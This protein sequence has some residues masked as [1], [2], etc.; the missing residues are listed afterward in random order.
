MKVT[1]TWHGDRRFVGRGPSGVPVLINFGPGETAA[2]PPAGPAADEDGTRAAGPSP[3]ELLLIATGACT[4]LDV[5]SILQ[6]KRVA[7]SGLEIE[8]GGWR[9][10]DHP[11]Y[12]TRLEVVYRLKAPPGARPGPEHAL[13]HAARLSMERYCSVGCSLRADKSW[14]CEVVPEDPPA[15]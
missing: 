2:G 7:F 8:V 4:G 11:R 3:V 5:V 15:T 13:E 14:R 12:F 1:V 6:K 10:P 9:A